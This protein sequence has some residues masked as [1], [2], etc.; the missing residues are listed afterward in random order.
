MNKQ[1][2]QLMGSNM[3]KWEQVTNPKI[4]HKLLPTPYIRN[5]VYRLR[6]NYNIKPLLT[7][8]WALQMIII[9]KS[10]ENLK[11]TSH[12][13]TCQKNRFFF[14][15]AKFK[16]VILSSVY[17]RKILKISKRSRVI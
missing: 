4:N 3:R 7:S 13:Q 2:R 11:V 10:T 16:S 8:T 15:L 9:I 17:K 6:A 12:L 1:D 14:Y 5:L